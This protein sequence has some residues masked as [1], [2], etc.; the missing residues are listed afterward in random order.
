M[1]KAGLFER[2]QR[3]D[4]L[5]PSVIALVAANLVPLAGVFLFHWEVFPL[6]FLFWLENIVIGVINA[7]KMI[8]ASGGLLDSAS[9]GAV[10]GD[11]LARAGES[12]DPKVQAQLKQLEGLNAAM[13]GAGGWV[14]KLFL[15]PFFCFHYGMFTFVHG[16]F[17]VTLFGKYHLGGG[18][19]DVSTISTIIRENHLMIPF[20]ALAASR[21]VSFVQNY[22]WRGEFRRTNAARLMIQPYSR[23]VVMHL[24]ILFGA[25]LMVLMHSPA[26]GLVML[27]ILK[28]GLDLAGHQAEREK[29]APATDR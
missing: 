21:F 7:A 14:L 28:T 17:V 11:R 12:S 20:L 25:F 3:I 16:I 22:L 9:A 8:L 29:L 24:T 13:R 2:L 4:W 5:Q 10:L 15:V 18:S 26:A 6:L 19:L 27:V 1:P 23:V